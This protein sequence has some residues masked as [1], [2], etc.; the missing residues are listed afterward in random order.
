MVFETYSLYCAEANAAANIPKWPS[1][2]DSTVVSTQE[3][4][5]LK[6]LTCPKIQV[7]AIRI[8]EPALQY[9]KRLYRFSL[10]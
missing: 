3:G 7:I 8:E 9:W 4:Q 5:T 1:K 10:M 6:F 2:K